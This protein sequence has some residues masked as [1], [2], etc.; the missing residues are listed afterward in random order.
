MHETRYYTL[1]LSMR[2]STAGKQL[3]DS[4]VVFSAESWFHREINTWSRD[5]KH[6][7][8]HLSEVK[9]AG[10]GSNVYYV[11]T[12][13]VRADR[14]PDSSAKLVN[15]VHLDGGAV[16]KLN[17]LVVTDMIR[18]KIR[19]QE[20]EQ[21]LADLEDEEIE[22]EVEAFEKVCGLFGVERSV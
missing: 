15:V 19:K 5:D 2:D 11:N 7:Q 4:R 6:I 17:K 1:D 12:H 9:I 20:L 18:F 16:Q 21:Q 13:Y 3:V 8:M 22:A 10:A 14:P